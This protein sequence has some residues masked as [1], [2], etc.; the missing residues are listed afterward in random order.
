VEGSRRWRWRNVP[1]PESHLVL[2]A[3]GI[4]L[5]AFWSRRITSTRG[6]RPL[7]GSL[8]IVGAVV[9]AWATRTA[10]PVDLERPARLVTRGPYAVSRHPMYVAW[11][12]IY[13]GVALVFN[14]LW[15]LVLLPL[16]GLLVHRE[17]RREES[18]LED[19]FGDAYR[20]YRR[21]VRRYF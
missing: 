3:A 7:G 20:T 17:A 1:L 14:V 15:L 5:N 6:V 13:V 18:R 10:G 12:L 8:I 16:L 2:M 19:A 4:V 9:A 11:T 21:R